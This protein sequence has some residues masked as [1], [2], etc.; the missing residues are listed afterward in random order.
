MGACTN[1]DILHGEAIYKGIAVGSIFIYKRC[2]TMIDKKD[3]VDATG[4]IVRFEKAKEV[5]REQ[6]IKLYEKAEKETGKVIALIF[7]AQQMIL[8]DMEYVKSVTD[9]IYKDHV[10]TEYAL[11]CIKDHYIALFQAMDNDYIMSKISDIKDVT[12]RMLIILQEKKQVESSIQKPIII[13]AEDLTPGE[14]VQF[15]KSK[16]A[17]LIIKNLSIHSHAAIVAEAMDIPVLAG[18]PESNLYHGRFAVVDGNHGMLYIDPTDDILSNFLTLQKADLAYKTHLEDLIG[19]ENRTKDGRTIKISANIGSIS[20]AFRAMNYDADGIGL[21]RSEFL[22][23]DRENY[24]GEEEQFQVYREVALKMKDKS[25]VIRTL[26]IGAD[27]QA[28]YFNLKEEQN[29]A[30]GFRGIRICLERKE[31]FI[32]QLRAIYRASSFGNV[33]IMYP[34]IISLDEVKEIKEIVEEV[35]R[36]LKRQGFSYGD[37]KQGIMIETPAAA[38][39]SDLLA[40]EVDFFSI[41]TNDLT[42]Y[43]LAIDRQNKELVKYYNP[44]HEAVLR[45]IRMIIENGHREGC[46]VAICGELGSDLSLT[47][48]FIDLGLD[49]VSVSPPLILKVR[50][51]VRKC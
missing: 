50:E 36:E 8:D 30:M 6:L 38:M 47:K 44:H 21:F 34:M 7:E 26:D 12:E 25:V 27:K 18:I 29:P 43:T 13:M 40:K 33:A 45:M 42:Q 17:A 39:I 19:V 10:N 32:T 22:F 49:E 11:S 2:I 20:D 46:K 51:M 23:L 14:I 28:D 41:G 15:D 24:P 4:E 48:Y 35:K 9:M 1:M 31:L 3:I 16:T 5:A 37:V